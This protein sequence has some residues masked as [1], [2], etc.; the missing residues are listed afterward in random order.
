MVII[1]AFPQGGPA[2]HLTLT[3][4]ASYGYDLTVV[5]G[6][7]RE[8]GTDANVA[9]VI[10]GSEAESQP[11]ILQKDMIN[12]RKILARGNDDRFVIHLPMS[13]GIVQYIRVWHD[14]SERVLLGI[15][16]MLL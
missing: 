11:I 4:E 7:W 10:H 5:T 12:S 3:Q 1:Y 9:I 13:L 6:V 16:A 2:F 14:N 8:S 15:S